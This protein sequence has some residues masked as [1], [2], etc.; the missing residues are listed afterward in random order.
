LANARPLLT[1]ASTT[2]MEYLKGVH[3]P[4]QGQHYRAALA[5][6]LWE[7]NMRWT[8]MGLLLVG[9]EPLGP[10]FAMSVV[11]FEP[12]ENAGFGQDQLPDVVLGAP[13]GAGEGAG[14]LHVLS[15]GNEGSIILEMDFIMEDGDGADLI[16]FEN[17]FIGFNEFGVVGVSE[18][19]ETFTE[20]PCAED[21]LGC[22]GVNPVLSHP[23]N[24]IDPTDP[25]VSGGDAFDLQAIGVE[26][27]VFVRIR[28]TGLNEY[29]GTSGGFDLDAVSIVQ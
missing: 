2:T 21:G 28:D 12:G 20:W 24:G 17:P 16:V 13:Q 8:W 14:S 9:C 19:G 27:A 18:D 25:S 11:S 1:S 5:G 4:A 6:K 3:H 22:A 7:T 26:R 15:L 23:E 29:L 10:G